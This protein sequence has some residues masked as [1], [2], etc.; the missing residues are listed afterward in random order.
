MPA[1]WDFS[2]PTAR[3]HDPDGYRGSEQRTDRTPVAT[4]K[5]DEAEPAKD[6]EKTA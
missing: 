2:D 1:R 4:G 5:D 6:E 3:R